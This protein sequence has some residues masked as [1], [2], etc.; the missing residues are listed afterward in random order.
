MCFYVIA[1]GTVRQEENGRAADPVPNWE[2]RGLA[3]V[4]QIS[5]NGVHGSLFRG[6]PIR[7]RRESQIH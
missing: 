7:A 2:F 3:R 6:S 5:A 4:E 1:V